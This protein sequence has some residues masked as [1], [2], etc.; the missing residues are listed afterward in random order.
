MQHVLLLTTFCF[1]FVASLQSELTCRSCPAGYCL[2]QNDKLY[3]A[4]LFHSYPAIKKTLSY[5]VSYED[6]HRD[7][8]SEAMAEF[9]SSPMARRRRGNGE[10]E[11]ELFQGESFNHS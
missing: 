10:E 7:S 2:D 9:L 11:E 4:C 1:I 3:C 6:R 8:V 5:S